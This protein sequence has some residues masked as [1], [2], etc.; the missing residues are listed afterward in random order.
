MFKNYRLIIKLAFE[1]PKNEN[2]LRLR[3]NLLQQPRLYSSSESTSVDYVECSRIH[4]LR[5]VFVHSL[6]F[7]LTV[8][9]ESPETFDAGSLVSPDVETM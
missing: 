5:V 4:L 1:F 6:V 7:S 2:L 9:V 8:S 3:L